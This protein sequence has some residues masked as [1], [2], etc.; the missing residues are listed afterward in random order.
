M[1]NLKELAAR[2]RK[3]GLPDGTIGVEGNA[4]NANKFSATCCNGEND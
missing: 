3:L 1:P 4:L 2:C